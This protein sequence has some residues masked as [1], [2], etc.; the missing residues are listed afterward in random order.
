MKNLSIDCKMTFNYHKG[1]GY[2]GVEWIRL[3]QDRSTDGLL[4]T[5]Q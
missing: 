2:E 5:R 3:A 1:A 4:R